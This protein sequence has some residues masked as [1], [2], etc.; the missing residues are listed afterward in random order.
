MMMLINCTQCGN[1]GEL[2]FTLEWDY[3]RE[4]CT[5]CCKSET[6]TKRYYFC[7]PECLKTFVKKFAGHNHKW[8]PV[9]W[10]KDKYI[11]SVD[12]EK[13]IIKLEEKCD[14]CTITRMREIVGDERKLYKKQ[15]SSLKE[16]IS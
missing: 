16:I 1:D 6:R 13:D 10:D 15:I 2:P 12:F 8:E 9:G 5:K 4:Q 11:M 7:S 3:E 14:I